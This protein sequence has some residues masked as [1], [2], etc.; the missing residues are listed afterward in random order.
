MGLRF[1]RRKVV[2]RYLPAIDTHPFVVNRFTA[3]GMKLVGV[4][5]NCGRSHTFAVGFEDGEEE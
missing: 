1:W 3:D 4:Q 5:C 2:I